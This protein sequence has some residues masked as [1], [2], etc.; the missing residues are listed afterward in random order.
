MHTLIHISIAGNLASLN[1]TPQGYY[2]CDGHE[3][4]CNCTTTCDNF[5]QWWDNNTVTFSSRTQYCDDMVPQCIDDVCTEVI[6]RNNCDSSSSSGTFTSRLNFT[7]NAEMERIQIG[8]YIEATNTSML[9]TSESRSPMREQSSELNSVT[10]WRVTN[11]TGMYMELQHCNK[12]KLPDMQNETNCWLQFS[13]LWPSLSFGDTAVHIPSA[14]FT[15]SLA[16]SVS[17]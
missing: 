15:P 7:A 13:L 8:C 5:L 1:C 12:Y 14:T 9:P 10:M 4:V 16:S 17:S 3:V 11:C 2:V 6:A